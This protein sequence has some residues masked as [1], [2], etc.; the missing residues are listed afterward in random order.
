[1]DEMDLESLCQMYLQVRRTAAW[2]TA[3]ARLIEQSARAP[4]TSQDCRWLNEALLHDQKKWFVAFTLQTT[5]SVPEVLYGPMIRAAVYEIDPSLNRSFIS[6][7]IEA[8]GYRRVNMSLLNYLEKGSDFEKAG[9]VN[10]LYWAGMLRMV[11][12]PPEKMAQNHKECAG[13][14]DVWQKRRSMLLREFVVNSNTDVRRSI[15]PHLN[16]R[17]EAYPPELRPL[18]DEAIRL[19]RNAHDQYIRHRIEIQLG[20]T[21]LGKTLFQAIPHRNPPST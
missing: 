10:A 15:V 1:M 4:L 8:F 19:G 7:C 6:P 14:D 12:G 17:P 5:K 11:Q 21:K 9:A 2:K 20:P 16:L 18:I 3:E 13:L